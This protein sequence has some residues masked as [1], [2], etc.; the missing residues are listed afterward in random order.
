MKI[1][2][3]GDHYASSKI[4][5][6]KELLGDLKADPTKTLM[7]GDT[8]HDFEVAQSIG[9]DCVLL[10]NG[11]NKKER[12]ENYLKYN[13]FMYVQTLGDK[14]ASEIFGESFPKNII[15]NPEGIVTELVSENRRFE[16]ELAVVVFPEW[17]KP[18]SCG[19]RNLRK[20]E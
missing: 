11:H 7:I 19:H 6:G 14:K 1:A 8:V 2:G 12:L 17:E 20:R 9:S 16:V 18:G 4:E 10:A 5:R 13:E 3:L 15:V